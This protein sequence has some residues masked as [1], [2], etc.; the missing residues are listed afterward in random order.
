M[1]VSDLIPR[2]RIQSNKSR[3]TNRHFGYLLAQI[4][5]NVADINCKYPNTMS[6]WNLYNL[7]RRLATDEGLPTRRSLSYLESREIGEVILQIYGKSKGLMTVGQE[8]ED[9]GSYRVI[10]NRRESRPNEIQ[11]SVV[12]DRL[13]SL[14]NIL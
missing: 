9:K 3:F 13:S 5:P 11:G 8:R 7:H 1:E 4:P 12:E 14:V 2:Y 10:G 6:Q